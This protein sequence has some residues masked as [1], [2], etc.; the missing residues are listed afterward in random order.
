MNRWKPSTSSQR[1]DAKPSR[2][3]WVVP[4]LLL[5]LAAVP[6]LGGVYRA[7]HLSFGGEVTASNQ[8]FFD[9][10]TAVTL[11]GISCALFAFLGAFQFSTGPRRKPKRHR[12]RGALFMPSA[13]VVAIT[14]LWMEAFQELPAHDGDLLSLFR[15]VFGLGMIACTLL[16]IRAL[17]RREFAQHG[18][19]MMRT[20]AIGMG[21]GTQVVVFILWGH[22]MGPT[23]L[24]ERAYLMGAS[25][26]INVIFVEWILIR[27]NR[28]TT[29]S[30]KT[31]KPIS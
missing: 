19:W 25:W 18:A 10:P 3:H 22:F 23:S 21:A 9:S 20:Y 5:L 27:K 13:L 29:V 14:G 7:L 12:I 16:G 24:T 1:R 11:H 17:L 15:V 6:A 30:L 26:V 28:R 31:L 2:R 4:S 8:R